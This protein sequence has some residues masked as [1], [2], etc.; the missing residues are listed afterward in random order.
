MPTF[1]ARK[2]LFSLACAFSIGGAELSSLMFLEM[3]VASIIVFSGYFI[4]G[5]TGFGGGLIVISLLLLFLDIKYVVP[6]H[7]LLNLIL[8]SSSVYQSRRFVQTSFV[9]PV[10][11]GSF[12]AVLLGTYILAAYQSVL[13]KKVL[14]VIVIL[15][16]L[17]FLLKELKG[18]P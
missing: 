5:L 17:N 6:A 1:K 4:L 11:S 12:V 3:F 10:F 18:K 2:E 9:Y 14:G 16:S 7:T 13:L 8:F 15:F